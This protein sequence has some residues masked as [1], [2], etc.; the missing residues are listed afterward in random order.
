MSKNT[1]KA[2]PIFLAFL[3][4]GFGDVV[5]P[6]TSQLQNDYQLS[7]V[8]AGLVT[9]MGFIMFG[10]L[11]VPM[12]IYQARKGKKQVLMIGLAAALF[13]LIIPMASGFNSFSLI[14]AGLLFLGTGATLLQ[15][16]GNPIMR[17]VSAE[18]RY[19]SNLSFGQFV[20]AIGSLSGALI[21]LIAANFWGLD[22]KVLFP[23]Y[24]V[25]ILVVLAIL[26]MQKI[27]ESKPAA[28]EEPASLK[29]CLALLKEPF[30]GLM[31][32]GIFLYVGA[33]VTLSSKLPNYL[34]L[35]FNFD[36]KETGLFGTLFFFVSLMIGRFAGGILLTKIAPSV[37]LKISS[38]LSLVGLL[39]LYVAPNAV[40]GF[41]A[42]AI[43]GLGFA[44]VFPLIFSITI[45]KMPERAN[46]ISGLM[47]T[48]IIGG[49]FVPVVFGFVADNFGL[50]SGFV[51][52]IA[53]FVY[54]LFLGFKA[55]GA[56]K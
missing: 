21:P 53:S 7:N 38:I 15:V 29:S 39:G 49:A 26:F 28:D 44:N 34:E 12:S 36:I 4:M 27:E 37:F 33:E 56:T 6:L 2:Y 31:V 50:M 9:F 35:A 13:G 11:S 17:D 48:A 1:A 23:I 25:I 30:V 8:A 18:G 16:A 47:V 10:L 40:A 22:W 41:V 51:V 46:E 45:D 19:S 14:L 24:S 3:C 43:I 32:F 42:I 5:G 20:K 52:T 55:Q 54:M